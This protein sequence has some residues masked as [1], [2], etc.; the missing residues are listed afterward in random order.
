MIQ[1]LGLHLSTKRAIAV[2]LGRDLNEWAR[3]ETQVMNVAPAPDASA[4]EVPV[5]E[6]IRA[7]C[8]A[9]QETYLDLPVKARKVW[10]VGLSG[11]SGWVA[12]DV[13]YEPVSS[14]RL[15]DGEH[16]ESDFRNWLDT[17]ERVVD[18]IAAVLSPKDFF[19]FV[20]SGGLA[21]D[22]T[23]VD[24]LGLLAPGQMRWDTPQ[25][26]GSPFRG[27]WLPPVFDSQSS[28]GRL[29][30]NGVRRTSLPGG[31]WVVSGAHESAAGIAGVADL[32]KPTLWVAREAGK[33]RLVRGVKTTATLTSVQGWDWRCPT[34]MGCQCLEKVLVAHEDEPHEDQFDREIAELSTAGYPVDD[35]QLVYP[36]AAL[37]AAVMTGVA[38]GLIK[39]WD[40]YYTAIDG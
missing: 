26:A 38:S 18:K 30:E 10:G 35:V 27:D 13:S 24:R 2:A 22:A 17:Q 15:V 40:R 6:W 16:V 32:R 21:T 5:A 34:L 33:Y 28:T 8:F 19:R 29:S 11:P 14:L 31:T 9:L 23:Q 3:T 37:G 39:G 7:G 12:L 25:L 4:T 36:D 20:V 1:F